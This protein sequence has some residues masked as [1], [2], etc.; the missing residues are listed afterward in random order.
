M[1]ATTQHHTKSKRDKRRAEFRLKRQIFSFCPKCGYTLI[2]HRMCSNCGYYKGKEV[3]DV[4]AKLEKKEK[5]E[6][7]KELALAGKETEKKKPLTMEALS[8][9]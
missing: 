9:K 5:R 3:I 8:K 4:L 2:S 7:K 1:P 6:K